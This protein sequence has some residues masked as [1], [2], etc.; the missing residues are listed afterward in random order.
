MRPT[1]NQPWFLRQTLLLHMSCQ[2]TS[3]TFASQPTN[4]VQAEVVV[5]VLV[6]FDQNQ[7]GFVSDGDWGEDWTAQIVDEDMPCCW[8]A[9]GRVLLASKPFGT[10]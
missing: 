10:R 8:T 2:W 6:D 9:L 7:I 3:S 4:M 5:G 1:T